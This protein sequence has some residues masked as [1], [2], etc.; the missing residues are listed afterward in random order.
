MRLRIVGLLTLVMLPAA[1]LA[2]GSLPQPLPDNWQ[3]KCQIVVF[4]QDTMTSTTIESS[5]R[6]TVM[7]G[8]TGSET[9]D[10]FTCQL[11]PDEITEIYATALQS[12]NT[13]QPKGL[14]ISKLEGDARKKALFNYITVSL[15]A[16]PDQKNG[17]G[18]SVYA[19]PA[20]FEICHFSR[21][22]QK[23]KTIT[24]RHKHP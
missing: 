20:D 14:D 4:T 6:C 8:Q 18:T 2:A 10:N 15:K 3:Y 9:A 17:I 23:I 5:G 7:K 16:G 11:S 21:L 1:L 13:Y 19:A 24:S 22:L 12:I